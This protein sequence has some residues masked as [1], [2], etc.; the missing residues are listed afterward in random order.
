MPPP[1]PAVEPHQAGQDQ[2]QLEGAEAA[3]AGRALPE[4]RL[5]EQDPDRLRRDLERSAVA[6]A[7]RSLRPGERV[8]FDAVFESIP[9]SAAGWVF[10]AAISPGRSDPEDPLPSTTPLAWE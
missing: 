1:A 5:R 3:G 8:R 2:G 9:E 10:Q 7:H 6:M 4:T